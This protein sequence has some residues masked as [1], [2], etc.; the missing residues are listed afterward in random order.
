MSDDYPAD[1]YDHADLDEWDSYRDDHND[2]AHYDAHDDQAAE[3][4]HP[5]NCDCIVCTMHDRLPPPYSSIFP[6]HEARWRVEYQDF[7]DY[8]DWVGPKRPKRGGK[9]KY[10][11]RK[12]PEIEHRD[13]FSR[14]AADQYADMLRRDYGGEI[15][16]A[17]VDLKQPPQNP[18]PLGVMR[19]GHWPLQ[20]PPRG[21]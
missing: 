16:C 1:Y 17:I 4:E 11:R 10:D 3:I 2:D 19:P 20:A 9:I 14:A 15:V 18:A 5:D 21:K 7:R 13:F 12:L 6:A 8:H